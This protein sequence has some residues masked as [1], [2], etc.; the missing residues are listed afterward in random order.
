MLKLLQLATK[1]S[2]SKTISTNLLVIFISSL[3][4]VLALLNFLLENQ[5]ISQI[6]QQSNLIM[7]SMIAVRQYTSKHVSPIVAPIN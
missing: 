3:A 6:N 4:I 1:S 5:A 2:L 7:D